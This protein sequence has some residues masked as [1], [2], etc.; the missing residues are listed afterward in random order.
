[1]LKQDVYEL[2]AHA[3]YL[4][5]VKQRVAR[6]EDPKAIDS[7]HKYKWKLQRGNAAPSQA[8]SVQIE[9]VR[10]PGLEP[11]TSDIDPP[12][13]ASDE[14]T[15]AASKDCNPVDAKRQG[16]QHY[17]LELISP[18]LAH[19]PRV[20]FEPVAVRG[21]DML[22]MAVPCARDGATLTNCNGLL[23]LFGGCY[24][25]DPG[26]VHPRAIVPLPTASAGTMHFTNHV[27][28]FDPA[29]KTWEMP[30]C[31]GGY[32]RGR[33]DHSAVF[34]AP[35]S[36]LVFGGRG[37]HA[38]SFNDVFVLDVELWNWTQSFPT[39]TGPAVRFWHAATA[40]SGRLFCFGG[41][42]LYTVYG[43]L[44]ELSLT[45]VGRRHSWSEPLTMGAPPSPRF[46]A[47]MLALGRDHLAVVGGWEARSVPHQR[48]RMTRPMDLFVLD[49]ITGIWSR[50][51]LAHHVVTWAL[52]CERFL[53]QAFVQNATLVVFGGFSHEPATRSHDKSWVELEA[54]SDVHPVRHVH[55][56]TLL[57]L[58]DPYVY[59]LDLRV[60][61]WRRQPVATPGT[62]ILFLPSMVHGGSY[63]VVHGAGYVHGTDVAN[64]AR[65]SL[66][67]LHVETS[68]PARHSDS[69][70]HD[71]DNPQDLSN[72]STSRN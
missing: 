60:M 35:R 40:D 21:A 71:L 43:D 13:P 59:K 4:E 22:D 56:M 36:L 8:A 10:P 61:I 18:A 49:T 69:G 27:F 70:T 7:Y 34:V 20:R 66:W 68:P 51:H 53:C 16:Q 38:V 1:M 45:D 46:G 15:S 62:G 55:G 6:G 28:V 14:A 65:M 44:W 52:P 50:P 29:S 25:S 30:R 63:P 2:V 33:A 23:V 67:K 48:A 32:P 42:D 41:K 57:P 39:E 17:L 64:Q 37:K 72:T 3:R 47:T 58:D 5:E 31:T 26:H 12:T 19:I 54:P 9:S 11:S 24:V